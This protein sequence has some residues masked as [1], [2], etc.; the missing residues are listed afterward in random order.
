MM[1]NFF[2]FCFFFFL[3]FLSSCVTSHTETFHGDKD[4]V[5][6]FRTG[7]VEWKFKK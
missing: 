3:L 7:N 6:Y 5:N 4:S 1:K 2:Y